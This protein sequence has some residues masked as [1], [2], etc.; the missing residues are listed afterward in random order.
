[1]SGSDKKDYEIGYGK[2]PKSGQFQK[3]QSGNPR[4]R[5][6]KKQKKPKLKLHPAA[7][8]TREIIRTEALKTLTINEGGKSTEVASTEAVLKAM[9]V[10]A[11]KGGVLAQRSY[12]DYA[13]AEDERYRAERKELFEFWSDYIDRVKAEI[14]SASLMGLP[15]P[16]PVPHPEDIELHYS[17]FEVT[18]TG[19]MDE[20]ERDHYHTLC[21]LR[22]L[23]YELCHYSGEMEE[24]S[25]HKPGEYVGPHFLNYLDNNMCLPQRLRRIPGDFDSELFDYMMGSRWDWEE[26]LAERMKKLG[27]GFTPIPEHKT[28]AQIFSLKELGFGLIDGRWEPQTPALKRERR[29]LLSGKV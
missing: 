24:L 8:P 18:F 16:D 13:L 27:L 4:G 1:M 22:D 14:A 9:K 26:S 21:L 7:S 25:K 3:G 10:T 28:N 15:E 29:R 12:L 11:I 17:T 6:R 20:T 5:P 2:P 23:S 19:P